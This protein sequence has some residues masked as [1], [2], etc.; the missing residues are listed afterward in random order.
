MPLIFVP[1]GAFAP[2]GSDFAGGLSDAVNALP[3]Y[4]GLLAMQGPTAVSVVTVADAPVTGCYAHVF[5][6]GIGTAT[7]DSDAVT[8]FAGTKTNLYTAGTG[9]FTAVSRGGGYAAAAGAEPSG[10]R[11]ASFGND[12]WFVNTVDVPQRRTNNA[13]SFA[14]GVT[15]TFVPQGRFIG[16]VRE[17]MVIASLS[18]V[19]GAADEF[20][21]SDANDATWYD[22]RTGARPASL[23][24]RKAVRS[25]P[26]QITGWTGGE[27]GV[28]YKRRSTYAVQLVGGTDI[29]RLDELSS[30]VGVALPG[31]LIQGRFADY[32]FGG[33]GFYRRAGLSA[34]E[35]ISPTEI[36]QLFTDAFHF[37]DRGFVH[38]A[39]ATMTQEDDILWGM[40]DALTG[41]LI[42][43]YSSSL[44]AATTP[45]ETAIL[46]DPASGLWAR[47]ETQG[48]TLF[49]RGMGVPL[50]HTT[51][52]GNDSMGLVYFEAAG[53][54]SR[55]SK[56]SG[57]T[58]GATFT[59]KRVRLISEGAEP[60]SFV[61]VRAIQPVF[62][63]PYS[64]AADPVALLPGA[65]ILG[66]TAT[67]TVA[68]DP[69]FIVQADA[70]G[71]QISPRSGVG[72]ERND[73]GL[74][75][76][77]LEGRWA[78]I[79]LTIAAGKEWRRFEGCWLHVDPVG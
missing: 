5:P 13:G 30:G 57:T 66:I 61:R 65:A 36:D 51:A 25:R 75:G 41:A 55:I 14:N 79:A 24:G 56:F 67:V 70:N 48:N 16:P 7:Y 52:T 11:G 22:D 15:S 8:L 39:I 27:H 73:F 18:S 32:F 68:N 12:V 10:W 78:T 64:A 28:L 47:Y 20:A 3:A 42:W 76:L 59:S 31:S 1:A 45:L 54:N 49:A 60:S 63:T 40:E 21:W 53:L 34:P 23:A 37:N 46:H 9:G 43:F 71:T 33:D 74:H 38:P 72:V 62:T 69:D 17:F 6:T 77:E 29:F 2:G 19:G 58:L 44:T 35:K 4:G 26:G 50:R